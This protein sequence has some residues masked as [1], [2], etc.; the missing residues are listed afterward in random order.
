M[1]LRRRAD[2]GQ[3]PLARR[4]RQSGPGVAFHHR[5]PPAAGDARQGGP[6]PST[7]PIEAQ[8]MNI[9]VRPVMGDGRRK[10]GWVAGGLGIGAL[11]IAL[12]CGSA[13]CG[14]CHEKEAAPPPPAP[15]AAP[16]PAQPPPAA[17]PIATGAAA[18]A[19]PEG[20]EKE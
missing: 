13:G 11:L 16:A 10:L 19:A 17:A 1:G 2:A 12:A 20:K 8:T 7:D 3:R 15:T 14:G 4:R 18:P 5:P 6:D 9:R